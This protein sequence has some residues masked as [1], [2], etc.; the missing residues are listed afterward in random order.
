MRW[1]CT[2]ACRSLVRTSA[3]TPDVD[4][5]LGPALD[6]AFEYS[7][8]MDV[9][10]A[11][12]ATQIAAESKKPSDR[13]AYASLALEYQSRAITAARPQLMDVGPTNCH[14]L[15]AFSVLNIPTSI[16]L[17]QLPIGISD[18]GKSPVES[19]LVSAQWIESIVGLMVNAE[20]WLRHGPFIVAFD[21][22]A[23]SDGYDEKYRPAMKRL[24]SLLAQSEYADRAHAK[25][26]DLFSRGI[27]LLEA[28]FLREKAM[29]VSSNQTETVGSADY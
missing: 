11:V 16:I 23:D 14:A 19:I 17:A 13:S 4:L 10:L 27:E 12:S 18:V 21:R 22:C 26:F 3:T 7:F 24:F 28:Y 29:A 25:Q 5:W 20:Q 9:I 15:F 8:L 6:M 2:H 1:W